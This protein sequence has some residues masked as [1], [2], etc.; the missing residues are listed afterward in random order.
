MQRVSMFVLALV[1]SAG[2][3]ANDFCSGFEAGYVTGFKQ[4]S[5]RGWEPSV[6][7]CPAQ[8]FKGYGD[9]ESDYEHGYTIGY[10]QGLAA[11]RNGG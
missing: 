3:M 4:G 8:P 7:Y 10:R 6:P 5:G 1:F 2:V 11:G 9:P